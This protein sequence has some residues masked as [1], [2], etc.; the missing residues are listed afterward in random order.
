MSHMIGVC[1]YT[2]CRIEELFQIRVSNID[3][4]AKT[5]IVTKTKPRAADRTLPSHSRILPLFKHL[6]SKSTDDY[7]LKS[8]SNNKY[9]ARS[10]SDGKRF[11]ILKARAGFGER[12]VFHSVRKT[13]AKLLHY[14]DVKK[15]VS[16]AIL[17]IGDT[18]DAYRTYPVEPSMD[19]K[20]TAIELI[21][22]P[23][24]EIRCA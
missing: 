14:A 17:G 5:F 12:Y 18:P 3:F 9:L 15:R 8:T 22:Y 6:A 1:M 10:S 16:T 19:Q 2:G 4:E 13:F 20:R 7:L 24:F 21:D 11:G 23:A